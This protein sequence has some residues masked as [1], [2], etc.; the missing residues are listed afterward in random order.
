MI[1][2][3]MRAYEREFKELK[4]HLFEDI[5]DQIAY[6]ERTL[7]QPG[8]CLLFAGRAGVGRKTT[9]QLIS[10]MLNMT[11]FSPNMSRE[12]GMKEFKRDLKLVLQTAGIES[13]RT[14][15]LIEDH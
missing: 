15:L 12:Y 2:Q 11:F 10:H 9:T 14:C 6:T 8:G 3:A 4:V 7:S 13:Q 1:E 5:L